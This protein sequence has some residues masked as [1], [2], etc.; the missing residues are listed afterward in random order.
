MFSKNKRNINP[1]LC[2]LNPHWKWEKMKKPKLTKEQVDAMF[3]GESYVPRQNIPRTKPV[4]ALESL[5]AH[6]INKGYIKKPSS[7]AKERLGENLS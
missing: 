1:K 3:R 7:P 6:M 2:V 4:Q 5:K